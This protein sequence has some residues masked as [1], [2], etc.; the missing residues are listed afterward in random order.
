[1]NKSNDGVNEKVTPLTALK[2]AEVPGE[3]LI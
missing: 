1:M 3:T 2:E